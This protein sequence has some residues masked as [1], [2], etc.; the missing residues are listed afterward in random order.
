[1]FGEGAGDGK[2]EA[3]G[4]AGVF[5]GEEAVE[6]AADGD[7][8]KAGGM[9]GEGDAAVRCKADVEVAV[10]VFEGVVQNVREDAGETGFVER[11]DDARFTQCYGGGDAAGGECAVKRCEAFCE[12][13]VQDDGRQ[14]ARVFG[15]N[16]RVAE[17]LFGELGHGVGAIANDGER[18]GDVVGQ[19][20]SIEEV[21]GAA[22]GGERGAQVVGDAGD[23]LF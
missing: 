20:L 13:I 7:A 9:V 19:R 4:V 2:A 11:T 23:G 14:G 16:H 1:M 21:E 3:G 22:D 5:N 12:D 6:E 8:V 17:E 15:K 18:T 10:A